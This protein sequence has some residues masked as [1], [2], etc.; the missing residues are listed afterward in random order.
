MDKGKQTLSCAKE[1]SNRQQRR[2]I[3]KGRSSSAALKQRRP[4][5][6]R[7][8]FRG[9]ICLIAESRLRLQLR[10]QLQLNE[11]EC[12]CSAQ[13]RSS[14]V[15]PTGSRSMFVRV[16]AV[17]WTGACSQVAGKTVERKGFA[18]MPAASLP[19]ELS[20]SINITTNGG[21]ANKEVHSSSSSSSMTGKLVHSRSLPIDIIEIDS[22]GG[23]R[24]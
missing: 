15:E 3:R 23:G 16:C 13:V 17:L 24:M 4:L 1:Q 9:L 5:K 20:P 6:A 14:R 11:E 19:L 8:I 7:N 21:R 12:K 10:L 2:R 22:S 18:P